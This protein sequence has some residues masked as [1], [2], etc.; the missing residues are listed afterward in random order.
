[1]QYK[2]LIIYRSKYQKVTFENFIGLPILGFPSNFLKTRGK[3][4]HRIGLKL[5]IYHI[6]GIKMT[7]KMPFYVARKLYSSSGRT[8]PP[9]TVATFKTL[10]PFLIL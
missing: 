3:N 8:Y 4:Y 1:M 5:R 6:K 2:F 9:Y 7:V 10:S